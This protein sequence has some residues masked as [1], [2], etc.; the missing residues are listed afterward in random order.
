MLVLP[1]S[2]RFPLILLLL[3]FPLPSLPLPSSYALLGDEGEPYAPRSSPSI[4]EGKDQG[5]VGKPATGWL[6][7][8]R[9]RKSSL[10]LRV[11]T[12]VP[13]PLN[14][15]V[16]S[17]EPTVMA[18]RALFSRDSIFGGYELNKVNYGVRYETVKTREKDGKE[19]SYIRRTMS[20]KIKKESYADVI[21]CDITN[22]KFYISGLPGMGTCSGNVKDLGKFVCNLSPSGGEAHS[23]NG[24][25]KERDAGGWKYFDVMYDIGGRNV[26]PQASLK[27]QGPAWNVVVQVDAVS[28]PLLLALVVEFC[29]AFPKDY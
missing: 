7:K 25:W 9:G 29:K 16:R 3:I 5:V 8:F 12:L 11:D 15:I 13:R 10:E 21:A 6:Q 14:V 26:E 22:E 18:D 4:Y 1:G 23:L 19:S 24:H 27:H 17:S 20:L 28:M 2:A